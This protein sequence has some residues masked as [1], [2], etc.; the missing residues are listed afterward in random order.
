METGQAAP[1]PI[2]TELA[3]A[4]PAGRAPLATSHR[5]AALAKT[6]NRGAAGAWRRRECRAT[7]NQGRSAD[8]DR[9]VEPA[10]RAGP[11]R[12]AVAEPSR[13]EPSGCPEVAG[14]LVGPVPAKTGMGGHR[15]TPAPGAWPGPSRAL[16]QRAA[17]RVAAG[18]RWGHQGR[19]GCFRWPVAPARRTPGVPGGHQLSGRSAANSAARLRLGGGAL[20]AARPAAV[21]HRRCAG[22][23]A[24]SVPPGRGAR[25]APRTPDPREPDP[26][27][28]APAAP[29]PVD[30]VR[31]RKGRC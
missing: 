24:R 29:V 17:R 18:P 12:W 8:A 16:D 25:P 7:G 13:G 21:Q 4:A 28:V 5:A 10:R 20:S 3:G 15:G 11:D 6:A 1:G 26:I 19:C 31:A 2:V 14:G 23:A 22:C 9:S 27:R 30:P